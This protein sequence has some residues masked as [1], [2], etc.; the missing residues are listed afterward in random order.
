M[1]KFEKS[2][3]F[4]FFDRKC[5]I[6][7]FWGCKPMWKMK[8]LSQPWFL[9]LHHVCNSKIY[10]IHNYSKISYRSHYGHLY[11]CSE[12]NRFFSE[13]NRHF[14][15]IFHE[16]NVFFGRKLA[17]NVRKRSKLIRNNV[18]RLE[19][20]FETCLDITNS[21]QIEFLAKNVQKRI[22]PL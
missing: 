3:F 2:K 5:H 8:I 20:C 13:Q 14:T 16:K 9:W 19:T 6:W 7:P 1:K 18:F 17:K 12:K 4:D 11:F 10:W 21:L 22:V 15:P